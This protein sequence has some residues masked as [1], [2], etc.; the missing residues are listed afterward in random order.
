MTSISTTA[1]HFVPAATVLDRSLQ[2][3]A[4]LSGL[5]LAASVCLMTFGLDLSAGFF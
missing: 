3:V 4:L 1:M 2:T 5:G